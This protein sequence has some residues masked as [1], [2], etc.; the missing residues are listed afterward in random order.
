MQTFIICLGLCSKIRAFRICFKLECAK[1]AILD[2]LTL[3]WD[4]A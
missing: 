1:I 3:E 2:S 4:F